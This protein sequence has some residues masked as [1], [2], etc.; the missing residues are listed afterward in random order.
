MKYMNSFFPKVKESRVQ[1][2]S[3]HYDASASDTSD[4]TEIVMLRIIDQQISSET[5]NSTTNHSSDEESSNNASI[6]HHG[7][8]L[9]HHRQPPDW[10]GISAES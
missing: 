10:Y 4:C 1:D 5:D 7:Y 8:N 3:V 6:A 2:Q 9:R